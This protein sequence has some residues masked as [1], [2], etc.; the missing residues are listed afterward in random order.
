MK[1]SAEFNKL[2]Y[3]IFVRV[4]MADRQLRGSCDDD[5]AIINKVDFPN[6]QVYADCL[7]AEQHLFD[8]N[9]AEGL[10][11]AIALVA[12]YHDDYPELAAELSY[13]LIISNFFLEPRP[14]GETSAALQLAE[15]ALQTTPSKATLSY[16]AACHALAGQYKQA[17][18]LLMHT[19][20]YPEPALSNAVFPKMKLSKQ[21]TFTI[22]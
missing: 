8:G 13:T 17:Y 12:K 14:E 4:P 9:Y 21:Q 2:L 1:H 3:T 10:S 19:P 5:L 7:A 11:R 16:A 6:R 22:H 15:T 20:F 18:E